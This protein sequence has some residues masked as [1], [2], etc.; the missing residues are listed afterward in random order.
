MTPAEWSLLLLLSVLWGGSFFFVEL[1]IRD[2]PPF[3][4][5]LL[6]VG[7]AALA[8]NVL[9]RAMG[10]RLPREPGV[11]KAFVIIGLLNNV[12]PFSLFVWA[13]TAITSGL[14]AIL[15]A[16][17][18]LFTLIVAHFLTRDEKLSGHRL[19]G[20]IIGFLGVAVMLGPGTLP[21]FGASLLAQLACLAAALS[22]ALAGVYGRRFAGMGVPPLV[23]AAGQLTMSTAM[24]TP[25]ALITDRPW[26]L[27]LPGVETWAALLALALAS[28]AFAYVLY[29]RI[30]A[31]V[32]ATNLLLVT[33]LIPVSAILLGVLILGEQL[34]PEAMIGMAFIGIGLAAIDGRAVRLASRVPGLPRPKT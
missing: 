22:Y 16:T 12:V 32:G 26:N 21:G 14:A 15:N 8:L 20:A 17:T 6:R 11:W 2:L 34:A 24:L 7:L 27:A 4:V 23:V 31:G 30:L 25:I 3:T 29:F 28:T 13:Q 5:V 9:L 18:P 10:Q 19:A 33:F 1:A